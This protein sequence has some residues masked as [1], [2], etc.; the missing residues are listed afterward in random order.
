MLLWSKWLVNALWLSRWRCVRGTPVH[1]A[2]PARARSLIFMI[3]VARA[4]LPGVCRLQRYVCLGRGLATQVCMCCLR[5]ARRP[6]TWQRRCSFW[7]AVPPPCFACSATGGGA[8][9]CTHWL[10]MAPDRRWWSGHA[11][12]GHACVTHAKSNSRH[13]QICLRALRTHARSIASCDHLFCYSLGSRSPRKGHSSMW[14]LMLQ[15]QAAHTL[16]GTWRVRLLLR[17]SRRCQ[18]VVA[19]GGPLASTFVVIPPCLSCV[20]VAGAPVVATHQV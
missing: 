11:W 18:L 2:S 12:S 9:R 3:T 15:A 20:C 8:R 7:H 16:L 6:I 4:A 13:T 5:C 17:P 1:L 19:I 10:H 14:H